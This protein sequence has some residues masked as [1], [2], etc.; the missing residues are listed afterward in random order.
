MKR[1]LILAPLLLA[2]CAAVASPAAL[3]GEWG[4]R[5]V[6]LAL[7]AEGGTLEYDCAAGTMTPPL[8]LADGS[9]TAQGRHTPGGGGPEIEGQVLPT[10]A[11]RYSG[12]VRG[13]TMSL[14]GDV[15]NGVVLGPFTLRRG[16][17]PI[18]FRCL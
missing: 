1:S 13:D 4:G 15:E 2:A 5:H 10:F 8:V 14:Q 9:F 18:I 3:Q 17:K 11:V 7:T 6:G 16:A 12:R